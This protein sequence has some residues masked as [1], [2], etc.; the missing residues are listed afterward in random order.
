MS[1]MLTYSGKIFNPKAPTER[2]ISITDIAHG[3]AM[4]PRFNGQLNEFYSVGEHSIMVAEI[5]RRMGH[6]PRIQL[7]ALFHDGEEAYTGDIPSPVKDLL[8][9]SIEDIAELIKIAIY[10]KLDIRKPD[11][12]E[13]RQIKWADEVAFIIEDR[14]LRTSG[15]DAQTY[16]KD[17]KVPLTILKMCED[18]KADPIGPKYAKIKFFE[19]YLMLIDRLKVDN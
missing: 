9:P 5:I 15:L 19:T 10:K 11:S 14:D 1:K 4:N 13:K 2:M 17:K 7:L 3:L 8:K 18:L 12:V 16:L 6:D